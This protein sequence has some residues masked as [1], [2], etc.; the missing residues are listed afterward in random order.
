V[1][2]I[3]ATVVVGVTVLGLLVLMFRQPP[4]RPVYRYNRYDLYPLER[5]LSSETE[6]LST[7]NDSLDDHN[8]QMAFVLLLAGLVVFGGFVLLHEVSSRALP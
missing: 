7:M 1:P 6:M 4:E 5:S 3:L 2:L 8:H